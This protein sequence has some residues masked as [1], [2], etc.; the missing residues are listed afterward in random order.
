MKTLIT[1]AK[2]LGNHRGIAP[3]SCLLI[4]FIISACTSEPT[5]TT[6]TSPSIKERI[7]TEAK[8]QQPVVFINPD[9]PNVTTP[10]N[11]AVRGIESKNLTYQWEKNNSIIPNE[12]SSSLSNIRFVKGDKIAVTATADGRT[13]RSEPITI[14]NA[15][16]EIVSA[17]IEPERPT[18]KDTVK[19]T[20]EAKDP[21]G[22]KVTI[23]YKWKRNNINI[24]NAEGPTLSLSNFAK[25][26]VITVDI[27]PFDGEAEGQGR[28]GRVEIFNSPP[29]ITSTPSAIS[30]SAY[31]YQVIAQD[32]DGDKIS[33]TL[34]RGPS[35]MELDSNSGLLKWTFTEK[36]SGDHSIEI[37]ASDPDGAE[38]AQ[39]F[40]LTIAFKK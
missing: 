3:T 13:L 8:P 17:K 28:I 14:L 32:P 39:K 1:L 29:V 7:D 30:G 35:G 26:D 4:L 16:P 21:D 34:L 18:K 5:Q 33:Y 2:F 23:K 11:V 10:L 37:K 22:D 6:G 15:S 19:A 38:S 24:P 25:K 9:R 20:A 40:N 36:E 12:T 31:S 27:I